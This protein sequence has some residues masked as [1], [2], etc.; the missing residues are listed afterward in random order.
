MRKEIIGYLVSEADA[1][2]SRQAP[3]RVSRRC[4]FT[5]I[6]VRVQ[7]TGARIRVSED[8]GRFQLNTRRAPSLGVRHLEIVAYDKAGRELP[9]A[10]SDADFPGYVVT[11]EGR[12]RI[13]D[14]SEEPQQ[15][16]GEFI[17]READA[18]GL[19]VTLGHR[20]GHADTPRAIV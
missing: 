15:N 8:G 11:D 10:A 19:L 18:F 5:G 1:A 9:F 17:I 2:G 20:R 12:A 13:E 4:S 6:A 7:G 14:R 16:Y 3:A